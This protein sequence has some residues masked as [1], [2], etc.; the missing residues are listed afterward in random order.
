LAL[1][2][3]AEQV[4]GLGWAYESSYGKTTSQRVLAARR[5]MAA[6][7][8]PCYL[9]VKA[10]SGVRE[11]L[12]RAY[13]NMCPA[14]TLKLLEERWALEKKAGQ[15]PGERDF[16]GGLGGTYGPMEAGFIERA[17]E[18]ELLGWAEAAL[19]AGLRGK[20]G[21]FE[22]GL[23]GSDFEESIKVEIGAS[24]P[25]VQG[26]HTAGGYWVDTERRTTIEGLWAVG[27][28]AGGAP[29]K[30]V[31]GSMAEG[32][33][34]AQSV[35][36]ALSRRSSGGLGLDPTRPAA[37][38][39][40]EAACQLRAKLSRKMEKTSLYGARELTEALQ[41]TMDLY[42]GG[43]LANY[44]YNQRELGLAAEKI[45]QLIELGESLTAPDQR[46]LIGL[47]ESQEALVVARSLIAHLEARKETRW[48]G[49]G[50]YSDYP[51][52]SDDFLCYVNSVFLGHRVE[53]IL[54]PLVKGD[55]YQHQV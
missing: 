49:F 14:Q 43:I 2:A 19:E 45:N 11:E 12:Y 42:A 31:T 26:G 54:R 4:N 38:L 46:S 32:E 52:T 41:K 39:A 7:R 30:Y 37:R 47:W 16:V 36:E 29:Q 53:T 5:E 9:S 33:I 6:G 10:N 23:A 44:R 22:G 24:E 27:D 20:N 17:S 1:G 34:A 51:E 25:Y 40:R 48:P 35:S 21:A 18:E 15:E 28:A 50:E 13:L 55:F 8:G 3:G